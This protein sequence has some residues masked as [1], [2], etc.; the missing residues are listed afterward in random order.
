MDCIS[1]AGE[2]MN[3]DKYSI[4]LKFLDI[5]F[6][7]KNKN[8]YEYELIIFI[9][10]GKLTK[11]F[12]YHLIWRWINLKFDQ[13]YNLFKF[14]HLTTNASS[15]Q[16]LYY[17]SERIISTFDF[18]Y[19]NEI[20]IDKNCIFSKCFL[21]DIAYFGIFGYNATYCNHISVDSRIKSFYDLSQIILNTLKKKLNIC[22]IKVMSVID[23]VIE[24]YLFVLL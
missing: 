8:E 7:L 14:K 5:I 2:N 12:N 17:L 3:H 19:I 16:Q 23:I 21:R 18:E 13:F 1:S 24:M 10:M 4:F 11:N 9:F 20:D 6:E 15:N 22:S